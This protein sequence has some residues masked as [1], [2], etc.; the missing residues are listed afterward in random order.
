MADVIDK[1]QQLQLQQVKR[2]PQNYKLPSLAECEECGN[3]I[4]PQRQKYG[5]VKLC[6]ECATIIEKRG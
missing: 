6:I 3:E 5:N 2:T 4:P 1:A